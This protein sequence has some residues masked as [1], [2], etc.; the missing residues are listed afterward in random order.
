M[1]SAFVISV[2]P[3]ELE[4]KCVLLAESIR[5]F[6]GSFRDSPIMAIQP[7]KGG[8]VSKW[9]H[10]KFAALDVTYVYKSRG[11]TYQ[12][13]GLANKIYAA[14]FA[15]EYFRNK[16]DRLILLDCDTVMLN[17]PIHLANEGYKVAARPVDR[18]GV[19]LQCEEELDR[20]WKFLFSQCGDK[21][22][23]PCVYT[24]V[25]G[26]NIKSYFNSGVVSIK[27]STKIFTKWLSKLNNI[28][29]DDL[30]RFSCKQR[31]FLEQSLLTCVILTTLN[32]K[33]DINI[34]PKS[35][36]YPYHMHENMCSE[37]KEELSEIVLLHYHNSFD[38]M[39]PPVAEFSV[40]VNQT[41]SKYVP[42][43]GKKAYLKNYLTYF[44]DSLKWSNVR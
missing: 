8:R 23:I 24:T 44:R 40:D 39:L 7:R 20:F 13:Y 34:L 4:K 41:I 12:E 27:P 1:K 10:R 30:E 25:S 6:G 9:G 21:P 38:E 2:E 42:F 32:D 19:G 3:G 36:N 37:K 35:Y 29:Q 43:E 17:E 28:D 11:R 5:K 15:E 22:E 26:E 14:A 31:H 33:S 16:A 18:K